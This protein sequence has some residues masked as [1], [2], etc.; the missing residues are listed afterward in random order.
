MH[1]V[2]VLT[3]LGL[4]VF[5]CSRY[6]CF[7]FTENVTESYAAECSMHNLV[8]LRY[9]WRETPCPFKRCAIYGADNGLPMPSF[10]YY[11][12]GFKKIKITARKFEVHLGKDN[13]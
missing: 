13:Y 10:Q 9:A 7:L 5:Y 4:N 2:Y 8:G 3:L 12:N 11:D 6:I 1:F